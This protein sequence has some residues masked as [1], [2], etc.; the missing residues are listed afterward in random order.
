MAN[1]RQTTTSHDH[2]LGDTSMMYQD[3]V[4][5]H[6]D[7]LLREGD[8]LRAERNEAYLRHAASRSAPVRGI[9]LRPVRVRF[10][11]WLVAVG[12]AVAGGTAEPQASARRAA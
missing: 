3:L 10:G 6:I 7:G 1:T 9:S 2:Q 4:R 12:W 11:R 5:D 8:V